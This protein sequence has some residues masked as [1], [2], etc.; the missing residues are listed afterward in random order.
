MK[1]K[2][3]FL[4]IMLM[5]A[6][7]LAM[8]QFLVS[9]VL[10]ASPTVST[11]SATG[12]GGTNATLRGSI[13]DDGGELCDGYFQYGTSDSYGNEGGKGLTLDTQDDGGHYY[14]VW[15]DGDYIYTACNTEGIRAYSFDGSSFTLEDTQDD[16]GYYQDVWGDGTYIYTACLGFGIYAYSFDGS[17]FTLEDSYYDSGSYY[18]VAGD[19]DYIYTVHGYDGVRA[20]S[21]DGS[22]FTLEDTRDDGGD[23]LNVYADDSHVY[24][25]GDNGLYVYSFDGSSFS[26]VINYDIDGDTY[27]DV[28]ATPAE[29]GTDIFTAADSAGLKVFNLQGT[30]IGKTDTATDM[31]KCN[32]VYA[33]DDYIFTGNEK[34]TSG[35][36]GWVSAYSFDGS[37]FTYIESTGENSADTENVW[38]DGTY[39]YAAAGDDGIRAY[40]FGKSTGDSFYMG[41]TSL[42]PGT[43]YHYRAVAENS[44]G[45][46][47]G[48]DM[49]FTT[50]NTAPN[51]PINPVPS[52]NSVDVSDPVTLQVDV[53]DPEGTSLDVSFY[54][55]SDDSLIGMDSGVASGGTASISWSGLSPTTEY[56]WYAVANDTFLGNTSDTWSFTTIDKPTVTT[57]ST[58]SIGETNATLRGSITDDGGELCDGYFQY[59]TSDSYGNEGGNE[60]SI[61]TGDSFSYGLSGLSPG[62]TYHYRA[63]AENSIGTSYGSDM[64]FTTDMNVTVSE[65]TNIHNTSA[66]LH[67][68]AESV[69]S[70][71]TCGFWINNESIV[72]GSSFVQNV[73]CSGTFSSG[74]S[75]TYDVSGLSPGQI[76]YYRSWVNSAD[77]FNY[78]ADMMSFLTCPNPPT[79][80]SID[81]VTESY[82]NM[83][84]S[85]GMG[86]NN[87][88]VVRKT[89]SSP[90]SV[91]DGTIVYNDTGT[92]YNDSITEFDE[93]YYSAWSY[94]E[95]D[96][97]FSY[98]ESFDSS[99][100]IQGVVLRIFN[101]SDN[102]AL[103]EWDVFISNHDGSDV[104][105]ATNCSNSHVIMN[106][107]VPYGEDIMFQFSKDGYRQRTFYYDVEPGG[108][109]YL[110]AFLLSENS[111]ELYL[112]TVVNNY[113]VGLD[114]AKVRIKKYIDGSY[115]D[116]SVL[117]THS[118]GQV[119]VF[120]EPFTQYKINISKPGFVTDIEDYTPTDSIFTQQFQ[121][122]L[123]LPDEYQEENL[124]DN[125]SWNIDPAEEV[126]RSNIT[127][128]YNI[129]SGTNQLE[130]FKLQVEYYNES[131]G[132]WVTVFSENESDSSGGSI[133]FI[134]ENK[135]GRYR[136]NAWF[137]KQDFSVFKFG[138]E[139]PCR[140]Y[141][142]T[143]ETLTE[144]LDD[145]PDSILFLVIISLAIAAT[146]VLLGMGAGDLSGLAGL[147]VMGIGAMLA[148]GLAIG[149]MP[150]W[151]V[152]LV[153]GIAY[154]AIGFLLGRF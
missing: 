12:I 32:A 151:S 25:V 18:A 127:F 99:T 77:S 96:D 53:S 42:S 23:Y 81:V 41:L 55:A 67:G 70:G 121:L 74:D 94:S 120:L 38:S 4:M 39:V 125:I 62:T 72:D 52:N 58:T 36:I 31:D 129:T 89:G 123:D 73:T 144:S 50:S 47:Y 27:R 103:D 64:T 108:I 51:S 84:W 153:A 87:T 95:W 56:I 30:T 143:W 98:S 13:T 9:P 26:Y 34:P 49:T 131:V 122:M 115:E 119:E 14:G 133:S 128:Y 29:F 35:S 43:T 147:S 78:S 86:A 65:A 139:L 85:R 46:S 101:E 63:V 132:S 97:L 16:G 1:K 114:D 71:S 138:D 112:F 22:D 7:F 79:D 92:W 19:G 75:L 80:F 100:D 11:D 44:D 37:S 15:S 106:D 61:E 66:T 90:S 113:G 124:W 68:D 20:L 118:N 102:V 82:I 141:V 117:Y 76:Y 6:V 3:I 83:S 134:S 130:W 150:F 93:Y 126:H 91:S 33:T 135:S 146:A 136:L 104:Y 59:G 40:D 45:T 5:F 148:P 152:I 111:S 10:A 17:S 28:V 48:S 60:F 145:V 116:V 137:K 109:V 142:I 88:V 154:F 21:F 8:N 140:Q 105:T 2:S 54:N 107:S 57:D 149:V 69:A 24:T 110:D